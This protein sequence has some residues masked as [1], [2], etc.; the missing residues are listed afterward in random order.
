MLVG[1]NAHFYAR[2]CNA[3]QYRGVLSEKKPPK[4]S[5]IVNAVLLR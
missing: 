2:C 4:N 5:M 1:G 3:A